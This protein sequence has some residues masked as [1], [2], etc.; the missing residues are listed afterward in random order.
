MPMK[1]RPAEGIR[2]RRRAFSLLHGNDQPA[3]PRRNPRIPGRRLFC[4]HVAKILLDGAAHHFAKARPHHLEK[5]VAGEQN[6]DRGVVQDGL[7]VINQFVLLQRGKKNYF[8][9]R[10]V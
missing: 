3:R 8:V 1:T 5:A 10:V 7:Q 9:I 2:P 4:V 6:A